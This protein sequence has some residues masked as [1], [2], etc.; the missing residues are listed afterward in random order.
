MQKGDH[1]GQYVLIEKLGDELLAG[2]PPF[3][4][5]T[6]T[7]YTDKETAEIQ[8]KNF[9]RLQGV[10]PD[11]IELLAKLGLIPERSLK[12]KALS[13]SAMKVNGMPVYVSP[14]D[15]EFVMKKDEY[16]KLP[17]ARITV[18]YRDLTS[19]EPAGRLVEQQKV[20]ISGQITARMEANP[21]EQIAMHSL[22]PKVVLPF[23]K[24][25]VVLIP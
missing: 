20:I 15:G 8:G 10:Q 24:E 7:D 13:F 21:F 22:H 11:R 16:L 2:R 18:Y 4:A 17:D 19:I 6:D 9:A 3:G 5:E 23:N 25:I 1:I 12:V 14:I